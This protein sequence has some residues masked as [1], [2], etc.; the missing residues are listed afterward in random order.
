MTKSIT[1][2]DKCKK[3][4]IED[5][6]GKALYRLEWAVSSPFFM[7]KM[8]DFDLCYICAE[9]VENF[10]EGSIKVDVF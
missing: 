5:E 10:I 1:Y 4:L 7:E 2:C 6:H 8:K 3:P 9:Q